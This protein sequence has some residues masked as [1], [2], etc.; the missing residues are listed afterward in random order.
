MSTDEDRQRPETPAT[1]GETD[2]TNAM[3]VDQARQ[4][5]AERID[6]AQEPRVSRV[7]RISRISRR[8]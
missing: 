5:I 4:I 3:T 6:R 7:T 1:E 8:R 2:M